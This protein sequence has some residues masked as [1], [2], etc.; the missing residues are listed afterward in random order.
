M[1]TSHLLRLISLPQLPSLESLIQA[2]TSY[3]PI[4]QHRHSDGVPA[5]RQ[6]K[7]HETDKQQQAITTTTDAP[8]PP[9]LL[10]AGPPDVDDDFSAHQVM[11]QGVNLGL[12]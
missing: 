8:P 5:D 3:L 12:V 10:S 9:P 1:V 7:S 11:M 6:L 2:T 4:S